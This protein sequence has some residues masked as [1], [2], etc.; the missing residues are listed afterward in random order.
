MENVF[1]SLVRLGIGTSSTVSLPERI[2]WDEIQALASRQGLSAIV[3]DGIEELRK[4]NSRVDLPKTVI[5]QWIGEVLNGYEYR[6][7]LYR[8]AIA[9]MAGF[10]HKHSIKMMVLKGYGCSLDWPRPEHRP[11]GD[12]DIWQFG[13]QKEADLLLTKQKGI[14]VNQDEHHHTV[15]YWRDFMVENHYDMLIT[16]A[17]KTNMKLE[18]ILKELAMD[19]TRTTEL[20][21]ETVY[22]PSAKFNAV[23]LL[24]H[25]L[26]HFVAVG[27]SLRLLLDWA[28]FWEKHGKEVDIVWYKKLLD[29]YHM[30]SFFNI[31]NA[32]CVEDLGFSACVFPMVQFNPNLKEEVLNDIM[33]PEYDKLEAHQPNPI[34]RIIFKY[35][36][37]K[38]GQWKR[39]LCY[40]EGALSSFLWSVRCHLLKPS[41]I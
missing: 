29:E 27:I 6:Y 40:Q 38:A 12:I 15:F 22:L 37:W 19:D 36:R 41:S 20:Y 8:R 33:S 35:K 5:T 9:E 13:K 25:M 24:R 32:I 2:N 39:D 17:V 16:Y 26:M 11:S 10:Y 18:P 3:L 34:N 7:E 31:I 14:E 30:T 23:F 4:R 28:F 1:L 21:G